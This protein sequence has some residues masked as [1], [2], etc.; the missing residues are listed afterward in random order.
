MK[1]DVLLA[2]TKD[3]L[4]ADDHAPLDLLRELVRLHFEMLGYSAAAS[5]A[6]G[7]PGDGPFTVMPASAA[8]ALMRLEEISAE[9]HKVVVQ[10]KSLE[11][12]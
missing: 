10:L 4:L 7:Q 8:V 5:L 1:I 3:F 11:E 12:S 9:I 6:K 2:D